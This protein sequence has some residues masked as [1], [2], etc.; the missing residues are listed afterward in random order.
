MCLVSIISSGQVSQEA[1]FNRVTGEFEVI[2]READGR[3]VMG[4]SKSFGV[5]VERVVEEWSRS[6]EFSAA[7]RTMAKALREDEGLRYGYIANVAMLLYDHYQ[8]ADW[9]DADVRNGAAHDILNK[10]FGS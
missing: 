5:A 3:V 10:I 1:Q 9:S 7:R 8:D 4:T 6:N 2:L